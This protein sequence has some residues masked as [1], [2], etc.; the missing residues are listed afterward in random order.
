MN[1]TEKKNK[2][3][4]NKGRRM[5]E[6]REIFGRGNAGGIEDGWAPRR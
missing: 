3:N 5:E 6:K 2:D 4:M 1:K